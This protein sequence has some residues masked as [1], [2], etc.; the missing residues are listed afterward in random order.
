MSIC[1][2][3]CPICHGTMH[4]Q[5]LKQLS[6]EQGGMLIEVVM[7]FATGH[8]INCLTDKPDLLQ[9]PNCGCVI[10]PAILE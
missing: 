8:W 4:A 7:Y 9:C 10:S 5:S 3:D 2:L 1:R 6:I